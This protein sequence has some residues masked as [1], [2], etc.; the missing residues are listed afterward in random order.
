MTMEEA[1]RC[2]QHDEG[3]MEALHGGVRAEHT[4]QHSNK[5]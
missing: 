1:S 4:E 5:G 2:G 3:V